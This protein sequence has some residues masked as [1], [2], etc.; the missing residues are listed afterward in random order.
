MVVDSLLCPGVVVSGAEVRRSILAN[1]VFVDEGASVEES[2]LFKGVMVGKGARLRRAIV[3]K[4]V[5]VPE[6]A[7]IGYDI[8]ADRQRF[9]V[10]DSG[11]V[12]LTGKVNSFF[13]KQMAQEAIRRVDGVEKIDNQLEVDWI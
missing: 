9:T 3:D 6:G 5:S 1:R 13:Q 12:V 10:A 11:I 8:D 7:E 2:I 4:W